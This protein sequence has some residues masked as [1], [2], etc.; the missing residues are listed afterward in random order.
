MVQLK[1]DSYVERFTAF[2][3]LYSCSLTALQT[4]LRK[5]NANS[6]VLKIIVSK[7]KRWVAIWASFSSHV[8]PFPFVKP[9]TSAIRNSLCG[10]NFFFRMQ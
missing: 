7:T 3:A 8:G 1:A 10:T 9:S 4:F 6:S 5:W 2:F